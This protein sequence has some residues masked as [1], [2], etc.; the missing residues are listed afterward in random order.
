MSVVVKHLQEFVESAA[1]S[2]I[3]DLSC[4]IGYHKGY[5]SN[6]SIPCFL[7]TKTWAW[8]AL[9]LQCSQGLFSLWPRCGL[10]AG[11][12]GFFFVIMGISRKLIMRMWVAHE[13]NCMP[14]WI[15]SGFLSALLEEGCGIYCWQRLLDQG[16]GFLAGLLLLYMSEEDAFWLLVALLK[17]AVHAPMEGLYLVSIHMVASMSR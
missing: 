5:I 16:M 15:F 9:P 8:A 10:C 4:R 11:E 12:T 2:S 1:I 17:G 6:I 3:W 7:S 13:H 14:L